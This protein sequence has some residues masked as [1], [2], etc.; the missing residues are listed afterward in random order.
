VAL[1]G[2]TALVRDSK[3]PDGPVLSFD[4]DEWQSF[5]AGV[6]DSEFDL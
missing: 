6:K 1:N 2:D 4:A 3:M 5:L